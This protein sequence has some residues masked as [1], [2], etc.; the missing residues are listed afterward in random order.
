VEMVEVVA[1]NQPRLNMHFRL[2]H[3]F[4]FEYTYAISL[5]VLFSRTRA[6]GK[7]T[8]LCHSHED[9]DMH[10]TVRMRVISPQ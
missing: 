5:L 2:E 10:T 4:P 6:A 1:A 9:T 3:S 7:G 8:A